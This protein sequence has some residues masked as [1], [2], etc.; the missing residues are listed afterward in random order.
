VTAAAT[1]APPRV[2]V[3]GMARSGTTWVGRMLVGGDARY[4]GEPLNVDYPGVFGLGVEHWYE[5]V[6]SR[7]AAFR[8]RLRRS[9]LGEFDPVDQIRVVRRPADVLRVGKRYLEYQ[10]RRVGATG[11][12]V[13]DPYAAF[14]IP[15][16]RENGFSVVV[17][18]RHPLAVVGSMKALGWSIDPA[19]FLTQ[20]RLMASTLAP[21]RR[22]LVE[23]LESGACGVERNALLWKM[24][25]RTVYESDL[26]VTIV[27]HEDL[28]R[29]PDRRFAEV[30]QRAG[31]TYTARAS[32]RV[33]DSSSEANP[34]QLS[35]THSVRLHSAASI[36][37]ARARLSAGE[38]KLVMAIASEA[39]EALYGDPG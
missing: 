18:V 37:P 2:L 15:W 34:V 8:E 33:R 14:S 16:F 13:K 32:A 7:D 17:V 24:I 29:D 11:V 25:Y 3:T 6:A 12:V 31:L 5:D 27:R 1:A 39:A 4:I 22:E 30:F 20:H 35:A 36:E 10:R 19:N 21:F 28:C 26:N 23:Q 38:A 9:C